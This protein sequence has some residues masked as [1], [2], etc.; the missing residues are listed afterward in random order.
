MNDDIVISQTVS[1]NP[2]T[3][4]RCSKIGLPPFGVTAGEAYF[5]IIKNGKP[6][7]AACADCFN[8]LREEMN[9]E[10]GGE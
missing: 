5:L 6:D 10:G 8:R 1:A 3:C 7:D 2:V 4:F 9:S